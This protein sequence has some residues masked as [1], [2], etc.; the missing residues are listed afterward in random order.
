MVIGKYDALK[1]LTMLGDG[2]GNFKTV[3]LDKSGFVVDSD[4][5]TFATL[6]T[7]DNQSLFIVSQMLDSLKIFKQNKIIKRD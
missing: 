2:L 3:D 6:K 4:A 5:R 1:G 7:T